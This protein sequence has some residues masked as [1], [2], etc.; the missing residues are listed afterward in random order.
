[1][2]KVYVTKRQTFTDNRDNQHQ[3][4]RVSLKS[5]H[6]FMEFMENEFFYQKC[7]S[8]TAIFFNLLQIICIIIKMS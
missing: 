8:E 1:M 7:P 2:L 4:Q 6:L 3:I 5:W